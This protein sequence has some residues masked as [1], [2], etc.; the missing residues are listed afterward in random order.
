MDRTEKIGNII[1]DYSCYP[2][3]DFYC[4]GAVEDELLQIVQQ[5]D[6]SDYGRVIEERGEWPIFYHLSPLRGNIVDWILL[7]GTDK[8]LE[9]GS[10]CGAITGTLAK[11]A[12]QVSCIELSGKRSKI[13]AYR[14]R[15]RD[16]VTIQVGNFKDIEP[17]LPCD[18]D[19]I[20]LIGVFE[21]GQS[22]IGGKTPYEDFMSIMQKHLKKNGRIVIAIENKF[23]LKYWAGCKED[24][25]G[26]Y[27]A[28][29]EDYAAGGGVRTFTRKG[30]E[31]ICLANDIRE[32]SFYYPYP[33]YK[34][35]TA[36]YSDKRLPK[37]GELSNNLCN[38]DR[39]RMLLFDEKNAFDGMIREG[40][41]PLFS[42]SYLLMI[43]PP[44]P[45]V[46]SKY[47]NDRAPEFAVRTDIL[48]GKGVQEPPNQKTGEKKSDQVSR[49]RQKTELQVQK[50]G[51][52]DAAKSHIKHIGE[53]YT[54]LC[55]RYEGSRLSVNRCKT[56]ED[57]SR[58]LLEYVS[59]RTLEEL[60]DECLDSADEEGFRKLFSNYC[61][62][63]S[64]REESP[65]IDYDLVFG[66][67]IRTCDVQG[68]EQWTILDYEWTLTDYESIFGKKAGI[69][70]VILRA[71]YCYSL[72]A[73]R[74]RKL[75]HELIMEISGRDKSILEELAE[76]ELLFQQ[77]VTGERMALADIRNRIGY[78]ILPVQQLAAAESAKWDKRKVQIYPD[79][80]TGCT[81]ETSF[82]M[83]GAYAG[84]GDKEEEGCIRIELPLQKEWHAVRIDP[85]LEPC[86]VTVRS[87]R[88][89]D[90]QTEK[91]LSLQDKKVKLNGN[92]IST[93]T[94]I[95]ATD[96]PNI[97]VEL[98]AAG[99]VSGKLRLCAQLYMAPL[100]QQ[101][102]QAAAAGLPKRRLF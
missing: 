3:E 35:T 99:Q 14:N 75:S 40:E 45:V 51:V 67:L 60:L 88:L 56:V 12:G 93:D 98:P 16:N 65:V 52:S 83:E 62:A 92:L 64:Y 9:I 33:D 94:I 48:E 78:S 34:F 31:R 54:M 37:V 32:Y 74:R 70:D 41:F 26:T 25:L 28:G 5:T 44:L 11:R 102:A 100:S 6:P 36:L 42:N 49:K 55:E 71:L 87:L 19:Y 21:Y 72:G 53:A 43:G 68:Q 96:D 59:G 4:D 73:W 30:L 46:Y 81:E 39:D 17:G 20:F 58:I 1:L 18:Y 80:G 23:G 2:G 86:M 8:V 63:V 10:G 50:S 7:T 101:M 89:C 38:Y 13:N 90:G 22:Y 47:S 15:E 79:T 84:K 61:S 29:M 91:V 57:G 97:T 85:A 24:H 76:R 95:F 27:F 77:Y 82:F 69:Q 66:N